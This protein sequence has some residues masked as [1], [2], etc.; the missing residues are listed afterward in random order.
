MKTILWAQNESPAIQETILID[1]ISFDIRDSIG[2]KAFTK[3]FEEVSKK[4]T[5]CTT[6]SSA[7][8]SLI[9]SDQDN[10]KTFVKSHYVEK[11]EI[12]R[13]MSFMFMTCSK[14]HKE[15]IEELQ[16]LSKRINR[17]ISKEDLTEIE[18]NLC[19]ESKNKTLTMAILA[20]VV[21]IIALTMT[22]AIWKQ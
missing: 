2:E 19:K 5:I 16:S 1:G 15:V 3:L 7:A 10:M 9:R 22:Y 21:L 11:D 6:I 14:N 13:R 17:T 4:K 20:V 8:C 18:N 12:G